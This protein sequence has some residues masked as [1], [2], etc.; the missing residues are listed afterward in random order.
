V[1]CSPSRTIDIRWTGVREQNR[2]H[3]IL[4]ALNMTLK[5]T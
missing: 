4:E 3:P 5:L 2:S 1:V